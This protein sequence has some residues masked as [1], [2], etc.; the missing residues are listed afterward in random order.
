MSG[1]FGHTV[2]IAGVLTDYESTWNASSLV[3]HSHGKDVHKGA[4]WDDKC[5]NPLVMVIHSSNC[6]AGSPSIHN[7]SK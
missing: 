5:N 7:H 2:N 1:L 6:C 3:N 4:V